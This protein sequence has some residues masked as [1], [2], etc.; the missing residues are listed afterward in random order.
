MV[1]KEISVSS[2]NQENSSWEWTSDGKGGFNIEENKEHN[3]DGTKI[4][5]SIK[6]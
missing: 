2:K 6:R 4:I 5:L 1:A 3:L